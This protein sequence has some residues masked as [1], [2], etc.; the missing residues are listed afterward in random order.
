MWKLNNSTNS[1]GVRLTSFLLP[2]LLAPAR[3][4]T[5]RT[6]TQQQIPVVSG[7]E[8]LPYLGPTQKF[9][10]VELGN[11]EDELTSHLRQAVFDP[12]YADNSRLLVYVPMMDD[13][14]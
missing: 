6:N 3:S 4:A 13:R 1:L 11:F 8:T 5:P 10:E 7:G 12:T 9:D 14:Q 2:A